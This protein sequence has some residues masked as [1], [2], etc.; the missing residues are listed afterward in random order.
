MV[1]R[2][3]YGFKNR[4]KCPSQISIAFFPFLEKTRK[5]FIF[6]PLTWIKTISREAVCSIAEMQ[7]QLKGEKNESKIQFQ[8]FKRKSFPFRCQFH[9]HFM[10]STLYGIF[11]A[12]LM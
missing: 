12:A 2:D 5:Q 10:S 4:L 3:F 1:S 6:T 9:Q 7:S 11:W 8:T